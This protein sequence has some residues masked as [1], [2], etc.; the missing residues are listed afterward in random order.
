MVGETFVLSSTISTPGT[1]ARR[2]MLME[3]GIGVP[4]ASVEN[5]AMM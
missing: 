3:A 4:S 2:P 5:E 1:S